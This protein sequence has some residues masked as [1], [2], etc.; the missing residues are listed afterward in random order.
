M[1]VC[2]VELSGGDAII[3]LLGREGQ[4][5]D[6]PDCRVRK[7]SLAKVHSQEDMRK[8]QFDF[9]KLMQDYS[10]DKV[11]IRERPTKGKFAASATS[12]KMEAAIQVID[13]LDVLM[14]SPSTLKELQKEHPLP[15]DFTDTEL[16][17]FQQPAFISAYVAHYYKGE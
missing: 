4:L 2:G 6:I 11:A 3:C 12:F 9:A 7:L 10:V 13:D 14:L 16:K 5:F 8:F 1:R 17:V 15:I